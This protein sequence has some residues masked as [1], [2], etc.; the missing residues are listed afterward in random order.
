VE[1][2]KSVKRIGAHP[3]SP[4]CALVHEP[5]APILSANDDD[6]TLTS[7]SAHRRDVT[8]PLSVKR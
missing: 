5:I 1:Y 3:R 7:A 4:V 2:C 6:A 8:A